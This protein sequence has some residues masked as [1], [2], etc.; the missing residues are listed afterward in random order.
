[1]LRRSEI[2]IVMGTQI[3]ESSVGAASNRGVASS[4]PPDPIPRSKPIPDQ[5]SRTSARDYERGIR[6]ARRARFSEES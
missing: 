6:V 4:A 2:F 1:M 5:R 3:A